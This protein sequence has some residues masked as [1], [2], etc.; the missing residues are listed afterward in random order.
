MSTP[1]FAA[2]V[3]LYS[4]PA[5]FVYVMANPDGRSTASSMN[6]LQQARAF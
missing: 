2:I 3:H 4:P 1:I 6:A 5:D